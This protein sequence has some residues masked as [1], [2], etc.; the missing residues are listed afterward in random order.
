MTGP[1]FHPT[2]LPAEPFGVTPAVVR[3][4]EDEGIERL[5]PPLGD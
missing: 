5:W 3:E 4:V 2:R 1:R